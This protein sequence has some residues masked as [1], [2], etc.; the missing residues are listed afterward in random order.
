[1]PRILT[2]QHKA[3]SDHSH[4]CIVDGLPGGGAF[5][6]PTELRQLA[7]QL[8]TIANDAEQ[9]VRGQATYNTEQQGAQAEGV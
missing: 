7:R 3:R 4:F 8:S 2:I 1:M 5:M 9:G 6:T